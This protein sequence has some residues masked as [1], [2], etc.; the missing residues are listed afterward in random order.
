MSFERPVGRVDT[1]E[2][3]WMGARPLDWALRDARWHLPFGVTGI[4][5]EVGVGRSGWLTRLAGS[6]WFS[7]L[8]PHA[9][10]LAIGEEPSGRWI[11]PPRSGEAGVAS[12][13]ASSHAPQAQWWAAVAVTPETGAAHRSAVLGLVRALRQRRSQSGDPLP[14]VVT[15]EGPSLHDEPFVSQLLERGAFVIRAGRGVGGD[16]LH[17]FPLRAFAADARLVCIDLF[18]ILSLWRPGR[19]AT[20]H[21]IP[22]HPEKAV[23]A[24]EDIPVHPVGAQAVDVRFHFRSDWADVQLEKIC[25]LAERCALRFVRDDGDF[26]YTN[27]RRLDGASGSADLLIINQGA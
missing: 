15:M 19:T 21:L 17:H 12:F 11:M 20:L 14:V 26:I 6:D 7:G 27:D 5:F 18:D 4:L 25:G 16:H 9:E 8:A 23:Q 2:I 3:T 10:D 13:L 1:V 24:M 22:M